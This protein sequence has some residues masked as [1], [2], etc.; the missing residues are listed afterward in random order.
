MIDLDFLTDEIARVNLRL[1]AH[2]GGI[3]LVH[4]SEAGAVDLRFTGMCCGCPYKA[5]TWNGTVRAILSRVPGVSSLTAP[6]VRISEEAEARLS[7][8]IDSVAVG[9]SSLGAL[10]GASSAKIAADE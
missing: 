3:D 6:G 4:V 9:R 10:S 1:R 8:Y 7:A 5:L 2:G